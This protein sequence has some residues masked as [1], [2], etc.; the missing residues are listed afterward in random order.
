VTFEEGSTTPLSAPTFEEVF[1]VLARDAYRVAYRLL[2]DRTEAEDVA[3]EACARTYSRWAT[4]KDH[5]EPWCG[6]E[7]A[8]Y[9]GPS[10]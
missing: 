4:V 8:R 1:P 10:A 7:P 3:Q 6:R 2:G 9:A 5:A